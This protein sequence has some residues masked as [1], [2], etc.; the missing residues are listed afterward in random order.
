MNRLFKLNGKE[1][2]LPELDFNTVCD[3]EERGFS[4]SDLNSKPMVMLRAFVSVALKDEPLDAGTEIQAH[5]I[6][7]ESLTSL[8]EAI[9]KSVEES[10][11]FQQMLKEDNPNSA[12]KKVA[13][14]K[15]PPKSK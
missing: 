12:P 13:P 14:K 15:V 8:I 5:L 7:G 1:Y 6:S 4:L 11:F 2:V 9:R 3:L 10:D